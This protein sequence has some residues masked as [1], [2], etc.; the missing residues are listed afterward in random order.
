M[1]P[2]ADVTVVIA[3]HNDSSALRHAL[4][5]VLAQT[6]APLSVVVVDDA[7]SPEHLNAVRR[8]VA[9]EDRCT[10]IE[11]GSNVGPG[12]ARNAAWRQARTRWVAFLDSD[13]VWHPEKL[14]RQLDAARSHGPGL[15]LIATQVAQLPAEQTGRSAPDSPD[16]PRARVVRRS[17]VLARNPFP[18]SS[19]LLRS[20][21]PVRFT[22]GVR[23]CEDYE[24]WLRVSA[25]GLPLARVEQPLV[26]RYKFPFGDSGLS[27]DRH[28]MMRSEVAAFRRCRADGVLRPHDLVV[29]VPLLALRFIRQEIKHH[30]RLRL[31]NR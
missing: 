13:E 11:L 26:T 19:V 25:L 15:V 20:D 30:L 10:L 1:S 7:S 22:E 14:A 31:A 8:L 5:S 6:R 2:D 21:V 24:L 3:H 17:E 12:S 16:A 27:G 23:R 4:R 29:A 18:T 28:A 9:P